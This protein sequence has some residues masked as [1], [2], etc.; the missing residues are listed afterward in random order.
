M[1]TTQSVLS[2]RENTKYMMDCGDVV[3]DATLER[4]ACHPKWRTFG[5]LLNHRQSS[6]PECNVRAKRVTLKD[7]P[8]ILFIAKRQIEPLEELC[9]DYKDPKCRS[10]LQPV[11]RSASQPVTSG[12]AP[13]TE[14]STNSQP[15]VPSCL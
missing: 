10:E 4:C 5:R 9:F 6:H 15:L 11:T 13:L 3:F 7:K 1:I 2:E 14:S 8:V 12:V